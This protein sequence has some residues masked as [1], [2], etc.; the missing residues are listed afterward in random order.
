MPFPVSHQAELINKKTDRMLHLLAICLAVNPQNIDD[1][2]SSLMKETVGESEMS[3]MQSGDINAFEQTFEHACPKFINPAM[4]TFENYIDDETRSIQVQTFLNEIKECM[5]PQELTSI[6]QLCKT[7]GLEKLA[8][9]AR[10]SETETLTEELLAFKIKN[11]QL[12]HKGSKSPVS[13]TWTHASSVDCLIKND[14]VTVAESVEVDRYAQY[15]IGQILKY[16]D[17]ITDAR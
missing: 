2:V 9:L 3:H 7:V 13:G 8:G 15:F 10:K 14:L 12:R 16:E 11:K 17:F 5:G 1:G 4:P 6:L